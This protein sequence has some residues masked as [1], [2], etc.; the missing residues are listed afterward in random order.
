[1]TPYGLLV[2]AGTLAV[3][4]ATPGPSTLSVAARVLARGSRGAVAY[5]AGL[6]IGDLAWLATATLGLAALAAHAAFAMRALVVAG[7][8]YLLVLARG[9]WHAQ[10]ARE[11]SPTAAGWGIVEGVVFQLGNPKVALFYLALVPVVV[12]LDRITGQGFALLALVVACV[13][14]L[15]NALYVALALAARRRA[16]TPRSL[17]ALHRAGAIV[18]VLAAIV[19]AWPALAP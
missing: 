8:V 19:L 17:H 6:V 10:P 7:A 11:P 1:M 12:P 18:M 15:V 13:I 14:A 3:A 16:R 9:M 4:A 2:F 5:C